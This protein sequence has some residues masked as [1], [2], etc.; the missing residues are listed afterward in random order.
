MHAQQAGNK[1]RAFVGRAREFAALASAVD[2]ASGGRGTLCLVNGEPGIGKSRLL[3]EFAA[4]QARAGGSIHWGLAWEA[5][6]AP[7]YWPWIQIL[8]S[9]LAQE[10]ARAALNEQ[11][12]LAQAIGELVPEL[13]PAQAHQGARLEP[14]QARFR[15]MDAVSGLLVAATAHAPLVLIFEDLHAVDV[16][17]LALLEFATRQLHSSRA[18]LIGTFRDADIQRPRVGN[19]VARLRRSAIQLALRRLDRDEIR[20]YMRVATGERPLEQQVTELATLT[21]GHPLYLAELVELGLARGSLLNAPPSV[22]MA[23]LERAAD[24]P[25]ETRQ[26]LGTASVLG[27]SFKR[28]ALAE[29]SFRDEADLLAHLAP[30]LASG[31]IEP[32]TP[33][34][35]RFEHMLVR[36]AFHDALPPAERRV[37]H[38]REAHRIQSRASRGAALPWAALAQHL[39]ES[40]EAARTEAVGAWGSAA[41]EADAR[42]AF[43]D[44]AVCF[45]RALLVL[46]DAP[47]SA[48]ARGRLVLELATAQIRAGDLDAGR[49]NSTEAFRIGESLDDTGLLADAALTYGSIFTF[50][51][52]DP[53]LVS[54]LKTALSRCDEH[55]ADR[56]ARLQARLAAAM[57]P[58]ADPSEPLA[59]ARDAIELARASGNER[60]LLVTLRSAVS[61]LMDLGDPVERL[62]LNQEH[63]RL[64]RKLGD[65]PECMRGYMRSAVDAMEL[66]DAATLDDAIEQC[67]TLADQ[68][69]LPH[70]QW[71]AA[72]FRVMRATSRGEFAA[73][74]AALATARRFAERAQDSNATLTLLIQQ[75]ALAEMTGDREK[76][77]A[78][79]VRLDRKCANLPQSEMYLKPDLL[80]IA[81]CVLGR[82]PDREAIDEDFLHR[83]LRFSDMGA[84]ASAG[85]YVAALRD[86]PLAQI[87]YRGIAPYRDRCGHWGMLGL[88]WMGPI[89]R[90]LGHLA[91]TI[92]EIE[93]A[94][95]H[96]AAALQIS[97]RMGAR[98]W[99]ARILVDWVEVLQQAGA[100]PSRAAHLLD[101]AATIASELGLSHFE[102]RI[103]RCRVALREAP[104]SSG[105]REPSTAAAAALHAADFFQLT[106][107]GEIWVC[108]CEGKVFRLRDSRGMQ[109]LAQLVATPGK[110]IHVLDLMGTAAAEDS[111][112]SG[113]CGE[114]LDERARRDYRGRLESLR[115]QLEEAEGLNDLASAEAVREEIEVLS[116]ELARAFGLGG[117]ARRAGSNV[118]RARVNVQR[119]LKHALD[120]IA[121]ECPAA[122]RH[123]EWAVRTGSFCSYRFS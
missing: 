83:M 102:A 90:G 77:E 123:L 61:A 12:H 55:D 93:A 74:E 34:G 53:R 6:G 89:A 4:E 30:A 35:L 1:G 36:E 19:I 97:R 114:L 117:R 5:G 76:L 3:A 94:N 108:E 86:I 64:A 37:L 116:A 11:P 66:G 44:A 56:R 60:T 23:I 111:V 105:A 78:L 96:F 98:P 100:R 7:V 104:T 21:E 87:A 67:V 51:N 10:H 62:A 9:I 2:A 20:E 49:R 63:V 75:L 48:G 38:E 107:D 42:H 72:S 91:A 112:D 79:C 113:D 81:V 103:A 82:E 40:G 80:A 16:D 84:F 32:D 43:D 92:G 65:A 27:R 41:R 71:T 31:L 52:I 57:Q 120:R 54:L 22:R 46:G 115:A 26:L 24:L 47:A 85:V 50:G 109:M 14:E 45:T 59:L 13:V 99:V 70:Y 73:A 28:A 122:G 25:Q 17:S 118:E 18:L 39:E 58:A 15:L 33:D 121:R 29:V 8:R 119:R 69:N 110:E 95:E 88:R 101:E 106:R 68:L